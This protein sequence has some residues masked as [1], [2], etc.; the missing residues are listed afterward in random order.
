[1]PLPRTSKSSSPIGTPDFHVTVWC[2]PCV[3]A[4]VGMEHLATAE[5]HFCVCVNWFLRFWFVGFLDFLFQKEKQVPL[6]LLVVDSFEGRQ[7]VV[8]GQTHFMK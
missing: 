1:M 5:I 4:H 8:Q 6:R 3:F 7:I 2:R